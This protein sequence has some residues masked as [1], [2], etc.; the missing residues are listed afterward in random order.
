MTHRRGTRRG[1][2]TRT[3]SLALVAALALLGCGPTTTPSPPTPAAA[4]ED[5]ATQGAPE[6][7]APTIR[8]ATLKGPTT[9]GLVG[10]MDDAAHGRSDQDYE[11][12]MH[13]TPDEVVPR[14][15]QGQVDAAL[16]P[17][18]LAS[19][20]HHRTTTPD[21]PQVQ[22]AAV[23][24]LGTFEVLENG[25]TVDGLADL[26]GRTVYSSGKG[27]SPEH[28]LDHLLRSAGLE[29]GT[30]V[31]VEY[32]SEPAEVAALLASRPGTVG[33][34]PQPFATAV[35]AQEPAVRT[36]VRLA[37]EWERVEGTPMVVGVLVVQT[38]FARAHPEALAAFFAE[39]E[40][41]TGRTRADPA[42][43]GVLIAEAG[44]VPSAALAEAAVPRSGITFVDGAAMRSALDGYL[45]VLAGADPASV[46]GSVPGDDLYHRP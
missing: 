20:L 24:A 42:T 23:T 7:D 19:V 5:A 2:A 45:R 31:T 16:L 33:V 30:D 43:A 40:D 1:A 28:V 18:N 6:V 39:Y 11:I 41:S 25:D 44:I 9:M 32:R 3:G 22:V 8:V 21:G 26:R 27:A 38:A 14:V 12:T 10:L 4:P 35:T 34:L 37:D 15:L 36:A 46:G 29:P 17:A 13:A